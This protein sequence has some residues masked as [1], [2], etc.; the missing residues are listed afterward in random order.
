MVRWVACVLAFGW[1]GG[2]LGGPTAWARIHEVV[3]LGTCSAQ[4][5]ATIEDCRIGYTQF[6]QAY[7]DGSNVIVVPSWLSARSTMM[8]EFFKGLANQLENSGFC[9]I[10]VDML[11]NGVSSSPSNSA[12]QPGFHFP[13][14][15][16]ADA[17]Q[18]QH[19]LLTGYLHLPHVKAVMG[20]SMGGVQTLQ[21][22]V[23]YPDYMD[24]VVDVVGTPRATPGD[25]SLWLSQVHLIE[26]THITDRSVTLDLRSQLLAM[27]EHD[28]LPGASY[29]EIAQ[30]IHAKLFTIAAK[31]DRLINP[32]PSISLARAKDAQLWITHSWCGHFAPAICQAQE[33]RDVIQAFILEED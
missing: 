32:Q 28:I 19:T 5:G 13:R 26:A 9:I 12:T 15:T 20:L 6:G 29:E 24:K 27:A 33:T 14:F 11:G 18:A 2:W 1:V 10:V 31:Y 16:I 7:K 21:W 25:I 22:A 4:D 17:V 30:H 8:I 3:P 23:Q